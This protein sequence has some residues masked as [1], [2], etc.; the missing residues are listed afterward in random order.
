M[1]NHRGCLLKESLVYSDLIFWINPFFVVRLTDLSHFECRSSKLWRKHSYNKLHL[2]FSPLLSSLS[3]LILPFLSSSSSL[4]SLILK[5]GIL[6]YQNQTRTTWN[7]RWGGHNCQ[8]TTS[9]G[10]VI[11]INLKLFWIRLHSF[12][13]YMQTKCK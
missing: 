5:F 9:R 10:T 11:N 12:Y 8:I 3:F 7:Q 2:F 6:G 13:K 4:S 1:H